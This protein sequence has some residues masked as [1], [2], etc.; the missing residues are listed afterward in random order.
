[1]AFE[2]PRYLYGFHDP[3]GEHLM[4]EAGKPGWVLVTEEIGHDPSWPSG[5]D[6]S[7]LATQGLGVIVR[8]NNGYHPNGTIPEPQ[9]YDDFA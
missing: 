1:M 2:E 5:R 8:L 9:H 7:S 6:Y 4:V 3:G